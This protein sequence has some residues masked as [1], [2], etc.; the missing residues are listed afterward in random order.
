MR[1]ARSGSCWSG[2]SCEFAHDDLGG[3]YAGIFD[4]RIRAPQHP[5]SD[6]TARTA[7]EIR[8]RV[9][10][11]RYARAVMTVEDEWIWWQSDDETHQWWWYDEWQAR[12]R[13]WWS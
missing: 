12:W 3:A 9:A 13:R 7:E 2:R 5:H 4:D 11:L 6:G 8:D 10:R 1:L